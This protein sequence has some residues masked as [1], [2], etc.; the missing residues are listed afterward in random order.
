MSVFAV[1][2]KFVEKSGTE[3]KFLL[4]VLYRFLQDNPL[5]IAVDANGSALDHYK[6][7]AINS[8]DLQKWLIYLGRNGAGSLEAIELGQVE[9]EKDELMGGALF[10]E[11]ARQII[12]LPQLIAW[13]HQHYSDWTE[14]GIEIIDRIEAIARVK[15]IAAGATRVRKRPPKGGINVEKVGVLNMA[16][17]QY[18]SNQAGAIGPGARASNNILTQT[19]TGSV[20]VQLTELV[21][22]LSKLRAA[23]RQEAG[24]AD[25]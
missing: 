13:S 16:R 17:D 1:C 11:I 7:A 21:A 23:M 6:A 18:T 19:Q 3:H 8:E 15:K 24:E 9:M 5:R 14:D 25:H 10:V 22:E 4:E 20:G 12:P 2:S